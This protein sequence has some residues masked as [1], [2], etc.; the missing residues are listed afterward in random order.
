MLRWRIHSCCDLSP[1]QRDECEE[2]F[3]WRS[4]VLRVLSPERGA[5]TLIGP[6]FLG[7][8]ATGPNGRRSA[9]ICADRR[10]YE[11]RPCR[12][13]HNL[14]KT[15]TS[16]FKHLAVFLLHMGGRIGAGL[17]NRKLSRQV[18]YRTFHPSFHPTFRPPSSLFSDHSNP[19]IR[20]LQYDYG[21]SL[22]MDGRLPGSPASGSSR[23]W[24]RYLPKIH[25][26]VY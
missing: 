19:V 11:I 3:A 24:R 20:S 17:V 26:R 2:P 4:I 5:H 7:S 22:A 23:T 10:Q 16:L 13:L 1:L 21:P 25:C 6:F 18:H 9:T 15:S 8:E 12:G 14:R